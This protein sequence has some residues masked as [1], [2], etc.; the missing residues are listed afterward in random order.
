VELANAVHPQTYNAGGILG[1]ER[2][3]IAHARMRSRDIVTWVLSNYEFEGEM[4]IDAFYW[5]YL[6]YQCRAIC[7]S[8]DFAEA[9]QARSYSDLPIASQVRRY[10]KNSFQD[11]QEFWEFWELYGGR[12]PRSFAWPPG[13]RHVVRVRNPRKHGVFQRQSRPSSLLT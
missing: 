9:R 13:D 8:K 4:T 6:A 12:E 3:Q 2:T 1:S 5:N 11:M 10:I 7:A